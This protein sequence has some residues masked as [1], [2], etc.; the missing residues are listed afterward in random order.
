[1][2]NTIARDLKKG[3][4]VISVKDTSGCVHVFN[5]PHVDKTIPQGSM[6][7]LRMKA[8]GVIS[9]PSKA[10]EVFKMGSLRS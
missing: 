8:G 5:R 9:V 4:A 10:L 6:A 3:S 2:P 1:M 7:L